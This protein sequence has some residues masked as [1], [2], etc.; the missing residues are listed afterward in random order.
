LRG[1]TLLIVF[2]A[3]GVVVVAAAVVS[4]GQ[5]YPTSFRL[6]SASTEKLGDDSRQMTIRTT[7]GIF[8]VTKPELIKTLGGDAPKVGKAFDGEYGTN[9]RQ[10]WDAYPAKHPDKVSTC[11]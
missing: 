1:K 9:P 4:E 7:D 10:L 6:C 11:K 2:T 8:L 5:G 3:V